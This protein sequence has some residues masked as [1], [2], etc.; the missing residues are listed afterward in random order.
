[1]AISAA[2][3]ALAGV[4]VSPFLTCS[5]HGPAAVVKAFAIVIVGGLGSIPGSHHRSLILGYSETIVA[6]LVST[7]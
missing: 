6:Y 2:T 5:D 3:A 7:S 4:L 1:M